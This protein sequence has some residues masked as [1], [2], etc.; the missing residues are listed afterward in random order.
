MARSSLILLA[1]LACCGVEVDASRAQTPPQTPGLAVDAETCGGVLV[2]EETPVR[3]GIR[4]GGGDWVRDFGV[5]VLRMRSYVREEDFEYTCDVL[6]AILPTMVELVGDPIA[7][8]T[9]TVELNDLVLQHYSCGSNSVTMHSM[10]PDDDTGV[11]SGWDNLFIHELTHAFQGDLLCEGDVPK[12]LTEGMAEAAR[13]FVGE[14]ASEA[15]GRVV[16]RRRFDRRMAV[17]DMYNGAGEQVLGGRGGIAYRFNF[18]ILYQN[19]AGSVIVPALAQLGAGQETPHPLS[20]L[21]AELRAE[22]V[23]GSPYHIFEAIDRAWSA[24]VDGVM[25]PSRWVRSRAVTC[26]SVRDG[27]FVTL[28]PYYLYNGVNPPWMR[29]IRFTRTGAGFDYYVSTGEMRFVGVSET[30]GQS[31]VED[32]APTVPDLDEGAYLV[33]LAVNDESGGTIETRSWMMVVDPTFVDDELWNGVAVVFVDGEGRPLDIPPGS[34]S[35]NGRVVAR[36]PGGVIALPYEGNLG[37]LTFERDGQVIGTVTAT[38]PLPRM[39]VLTVEDAAPPSVVSWKP[40]HPVRGG[41]VSLAFRRDRSSLPP[42]TGASVEAILYDMSGAVRTTVTMTPSSD[43]AEVFT[44][45]MTVP[46]DLDDGVLAFTDG[47]STHQGCRYWPC[48]WFWG[49]EFA[50]RAAGPAEVDRVRFDGTHLHPEVTAEH[51][52]DEVLWN[53][54]ELVGSGSYFQVVD[55]DR[56]GVVLFTEFLVLGPTAVRLSPRRPFPNPGTDV[57]RWPFEVGA[58]TSATFEVYDVVGR[59]V[60]S[61]GPT[62]LFTGLEEFRWNSTAAGRRAPTGVYFLRVNG[63]GETFTRKVIIVR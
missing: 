59:R 12:W 63:A 47:T 36:V 40:Y 16:R 61:S 19:A 46:N 37:S 55:T 52:G 7:L 28:L 5:T 38:G 17:Y 26:P 48:R 30:V 23:L 29:I 50:T 34:L 2:T 10:D 58:P 15:S 22:K 25:P 4:Q 54:K 53:V 13:F 9:L 27:E 57:V 62:P 43:W 49:Y 8:D 11:D 42:G 6:D 44:A 14:A 60:F 32:V 35:F 18:D 56:A 33:E 1:V 21:T 51:R 45:E 39:V 41:T 20:R 3:V 31:V 24:P